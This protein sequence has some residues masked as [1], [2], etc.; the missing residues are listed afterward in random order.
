MAALAENLVDG[1]CSIGF[2]C[3]PGTCIAG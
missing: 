1:R 3:H 2:G